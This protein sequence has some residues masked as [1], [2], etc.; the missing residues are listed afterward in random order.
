MRG[1]TGGI[2][3]R[4]QEIRRKKGENR[5]YILHAQ[6]IEIPLQVNGNA[7]RGMSLYLQYE[8]S[9]G[10]HY[11]DEVHGPKIAGSGKWITRRYERFDHL[12]T[13]GSPGHYKHDPRKVGESAHNVTEGGEEGRGKETESEGEE[14]EGG[15]ERKR[16]REEERR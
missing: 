5:D 9:E 2:G 8:L 10:K 6:I 12:D 15:C 4:E 11:K 1:K 7:I 14:G 13:R 3:R 16:K